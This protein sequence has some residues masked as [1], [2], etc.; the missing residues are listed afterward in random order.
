MFDT[1]GAK[2]ILSYQ[3]KSDTVIKILNFATI[4]YVVQSMLKLG[5]LGHAPQEKFE[6][7]ML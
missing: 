7:Y 6:N 3:P 5:G 1:A 2:L 4:G